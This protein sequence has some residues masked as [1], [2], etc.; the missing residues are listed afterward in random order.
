MRSDVKLGE[1][2]ARLH[3]DFIANAKYIS[4]FFPEM[5]RVECPEAIAL[6]T[7]AEILKWPETDAQV[8]VLL[9]E[10][11]QDARELIFTGQIYLYS[12]RPVPEALQA[13]LLSEAKA[14]GHRLTFGSVKYMNHRNKSEKPLPSFLTTAAIKPVSPSLSPKNC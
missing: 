2:I 11:K 3:F 4:L 13:R 6:N 12:E 14:I 5:P 10:E 9:G 8:W 7:V 1:L